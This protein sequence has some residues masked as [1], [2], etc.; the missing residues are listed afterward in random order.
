MF[1]RI[2]TYKREQQK[3]V[4]QR[5]KL[6]GEIINNIR[7]VKLYAYEK[8]FGDKIG[9]LRKKELFKLRH[10]C[11]LRSMVTS[12]FTF[13]PVLAAICKYATEAKKNVS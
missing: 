6:L 12:T 1:R 3:I 8:Y 7:A 10:Y 4:D 5:V 13:L 11:L 2:L 9:D